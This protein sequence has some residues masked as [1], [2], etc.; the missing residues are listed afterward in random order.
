MAK[1]VPDGEVACDD[2]HQGGAMTQTDK[3]AAAIFD[4]DG[5]RAVVTGAASGLGFAMAEVLALNGARVT[6]LD[7]NTE[8][9][10]IA[11][12]EL[13]EQGASVRGDRL[14]VGDPEAV[15]RM[16][17]AIADRE[18]GLD[19]VFANAGI[20]RGAGIIV[21]EGQLEN[22]DRAAYK[23]VI[24]V[25][26]HGVV[27]TVQAAARVM[28]PQRQ[29][30]IVVTASTA[31][32]STEAFC[33]YGYIAAKGGVVNLVRQ[34][35]LDLARDNVLVNGIAP[36]PFFT[37]IGGPSGADPD[38]VAYWASTVP[39]GR[40]A[41]PSELQGVVLLLAAPRASTFLTG[42]VIPVDGGT[43]VGP[44]VGANTAPAAG[45]VR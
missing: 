3:R 37:R 33:G 21:E 28:R 31:G 27:W 14:D 34:A 8:L 12:E 4:V 29:G 30:R 36:G 13:S 15:D 35:A 24:D 40:M 2:R 44:P 22:A 11:V 9:L 38:V 32:L 26:L 41:E 39:L 18:G 45:F 42:A 43:L 1:P 6:M 10:E 20:S 5:V 19:A 16:F 7:E 17:D 23:Q 25:N